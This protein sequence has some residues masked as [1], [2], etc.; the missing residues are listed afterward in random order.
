MHA[1]LVRRSVKELVQISH[2]NAWSMY[3]KD[4]EGNRIELFVDTPWYVKQPL[5]IPMDMRLPDDELWAWAER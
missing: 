4:P 1:E 5:R 2:G 3:F